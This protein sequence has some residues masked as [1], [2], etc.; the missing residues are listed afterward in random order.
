MHIT[1]FLFDAYL[2]CPTKCYLRAQGEIG[3]GNVY[4]EWL[5]NQNESYRNDAISRLKAG[6]D[7]QE[8]AVRPPAIENLKSAKWQMA[9]DFVIQAQN[10]ESIIDAMERIPSEK[11]GKAAQFIPIRYIFRNKLTKDDK[12]LLAF[13]AFVLSEQLGRKVELCKIIHG[14]DH[15]TL[16]VKTASLM[17][18][19]RK[20]TEKIAVLLST[21]KAP[22]LILN[23]HCGECEFQSRCREKAIEKDD[24]SLLASMSE[25][26]RKKFNNK[27]IFTVTQLSYTFRPRRRPKWLRDKREKYHHSL[28][29]LAIREK[30]IH[31]VGSPKLKIEGTPVY[32]DVEGIPDRD[33]Y[34]LIGMRIGNGDSAIQQSLWAN[35]A[36]EE[37]KIWVEFLTILER[38]ENPILVHYG[39]YETTF[40]KRMCKRYGKP[41]VDSR[42][43]KAIESPINFV[44]LLFA[45]VYFPTHS[46]SLKE[47]AGY[48]K[49]RWADPSA[50]GVKSITWRYEWENSRASSVK[51]TL[52]TYNI[53]DCEALELVKN[54]LV[55]LQNIPQMT[56]DLPLADVVC[57][58]NLKRENLYHFKRN[59]FV[60]PELE[61][62]NK[63]AY[64]NYQRER[65]YIKTNKSLKKALNKSSKIKIDLTP[66]RIINCPKLSTCPTCGAKNIYGYRKERK[67]VF[68]L[69]FMRY[70][71]KRWITLYLFHRYFYQD[72]RAFFYPKDQFWA[73]SKF[74]PGL[75]A[76]LL[77]QSIELY[78]SLENINR[79]LSKVFGINLLRGT[80]NC[81]KTKMARIYEETYNE[82]IK[83]LCN[84][85]LLHADETKAIVKG[86]D[87]FVWVFAN[88]KEVVY[89]YS[90]T[91]E[92]NI[93]HKLLNDFTG[94]LVSDFY[95]VYDGIKCPQQKC[96]IHL[97]RDLNDAILENP[98]DN[99]LKGL[100]KTFGELLKPMIESVDRHGLKSLFLR[101]HLVAV[102][103]FYRRLSNTDF[104]S[105][106]AT[107][108]IERFKKNRDKLFT[109]LSY[110]GVPWN[111][112][113]A[114]HA[115][116]P[117]AKLRQIIGGATTEKGIREYLILLS[118]CQTCRYQ[119]LDFLDFLRSGEKDIDV[120][121]QSKHR[122]YSGQ[123]HSLGIVYE[124]QEDGRSKK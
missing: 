80:V 74:G 98:Y 27:G 28:K 71:V 83:R 7:Q 50:S 122:K 34:Y 21:D 33:F 82:L 4:A 104:Q 59:L 30:K 2:K 89:I 25:K 53:Q 5:R 48:L 46:N 85:R 14:D 99:E 79:S 108:L 73:R 42:S 20:L 76:Y 88:M 90:E 91:R 92:G 58:E 23:R 8:C 36:D 113:N 77:Y 39:S 32:F 47:I 97:I 100:V 66:N 26:E 93:P 52:V 16:K 55:D 112:N 123:Y 87:A 119:G 24:L 65:V 68:D 57:T 62:I 1:T 22:D 118:I 60:F 84:G 72:C 96:L 109:F 64:W 101:K 94:V 107:K 56:G 9:V 63:A 86:K 19:V 114:E 70:G 69:K 61:V 78:L 3:T 111:N 15:V 110:D 106:F 103:R 29:A 37:K 45:Q 54:K 117:F 11:S 102:N 105:E 18:S 38:V 13:D 10:M 75:I 115:I 35:N 41:P 40:L 6:M 67:T 43:A 12:L 31:I 124:W 121:A 95:A 49:F 44:S 81:L 17:N 51:A 116:K 120:F